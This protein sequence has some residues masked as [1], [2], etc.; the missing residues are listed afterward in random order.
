MKN[1]NKLIREFEASKE[2]INMV[3][4]W[5]NKSKEA[6]VVRDHISVVELSS[7][8]SYKKIL[9][10]NLNPEKI[11]KVEAIVKYLMNLDATDSESDED[12]EK[13]LLHYNVMLVM[14]VLLLCMLINFWIKM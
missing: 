1:G 7:G 14:L 2:V 10:R 6:E 13:L 8:T 4:L 11:K 9:F 3:K 5:L 12:L